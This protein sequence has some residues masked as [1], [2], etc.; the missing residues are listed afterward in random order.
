MWYVTDL[1]RSIYGGLALP[2]SAHPEKGQFLVT[3]ANARMMINTSHFYG[4]STFLLAPYT[5]QPAGRYADPKHDYGSAFGHLG[6]TYGYNSIVAFVPG[7]NLSIAVGTNVESDYQAQPSD[8]FCSAF[9]RVKQL[10][11]D[12]P[13]E[14]ANCTYD[15]AGYFGSCICTTTKYACVPHQSGSGE[16]MRCEPVGWHNAT[17]GYADCKS[18]CK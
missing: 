2:A 7:L 8:V 5:G 6:A 3:P 4:F 15:P 16:S 11:L 1:A 9:N 10:V 18:S 13:E 14:A 17:S 12:E